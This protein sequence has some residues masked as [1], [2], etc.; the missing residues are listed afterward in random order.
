MCEC[1]CI[2]TK[3][4]VENRC[5]KWG[6]NGH[7]IHSFMGYLLISFH[8]LLG[9]LII[10][11]TPPFWVPS[12][13]NVKAMPAPVS[14]SPNSFQEG[15]KRGQM[16]GQRA[17][18]ACNGPLSTEVTHADLEELTERKEVTATHGPHDPN[19]NSDPLL[20][21]WLNLLIDANPV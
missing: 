15:F 18:C 8:R 11:T 14:S 6:S 4:P 19:L 1:L 20:T 7:I 10:H 16:K 2:Q 5:R 21:V 17:R 13:G 3:W 9:C 12:A